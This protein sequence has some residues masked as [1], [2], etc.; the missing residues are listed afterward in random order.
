MHLN[1]E[2]QPSEDQEKNYDP[3]WESRLISPLKS[4]KESFNS[5]F[6]IHS[7]NVIEP[8]QASGVS[9][10]TNDIM[11]REEE[12]AA[13]TGAGEWSWG[14]DS[15]GSGRFNTTINEDPVPGNFLIN[16]FFN[17]NKHFCNDLDNSTL[18]MSF[19]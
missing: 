13:V 3:T 11:H 12:A 8:T 10:P 19:G 1:T 4:P 18:H 17:N 7:T 2:T 14:W 6:S 5:I 15:G 9:L 16:S